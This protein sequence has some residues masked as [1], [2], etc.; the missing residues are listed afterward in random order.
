[1][2]ARSIAP[3]VTVPSRRR[4]ASPTEAAWAPWETPSRPGPPRPD[5]P[6]PYL[7]PGARVIDGLALGSRPGPGAKGSAGDEWA[8]RPIPVW[9]ADREPGGAGKRPTTNHPSR[10]EE[11]CHP[12]YGFASAPAGRSAILMQRS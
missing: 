3:R 12:P 10:K 4:R 11:S 7:L 8:L 5:D 2:G 1:M 6:R 9:L